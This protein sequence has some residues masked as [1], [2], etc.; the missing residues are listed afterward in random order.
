MLIVSCMM[1]SKNT[2][3]YLNFNSFSWGSGSAF[4]DI[5]I[6]S[7]VVETG[8]EYITS[9]TGIDCYATNMD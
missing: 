7:A 6:P 1:G 4:S 8:E 3:V 9:N 5:I 2:D